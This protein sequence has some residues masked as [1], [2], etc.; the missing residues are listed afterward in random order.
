V[1]QAPKVLKVQLVLHLK[2]LKVQKALK[3]TKVHK[4]L[5]HKVIQVLKVLKV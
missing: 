3:E 2:E 1:I 4:E 5:L